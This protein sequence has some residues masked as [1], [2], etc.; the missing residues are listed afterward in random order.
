[1]AAICVKPAGN[2][3]I[4]QYVVLSDPD[5]AIDIPATS[6][7]RWQKFRIAVLTI[8]GNDSG[9]DVD[10]K[11]QEVTVAELG[12]SGVASAVERGSVEDRMLDTCSKEEI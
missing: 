3:L 5:V 10:R 7:P 6:V 2:E 12:G 8:D 1:M 9:Y 4:P 11:P